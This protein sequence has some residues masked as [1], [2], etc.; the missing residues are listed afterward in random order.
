MKKLDSFVQEQFN[1]RSNQDR[2]KRVDWY[3]VEYLDSNGMAY[4]RSY[5]FKPGT[6][7]DTVKSSNPTSKNHGVECGHK[8]RD[9][10]TAMKCRDKFTAKLRMGWTDGIIIENNGE[11]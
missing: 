10:L 5:E 7:F 9:E 6:P 8:H 4:R 2:R 3:V 11:V 1:K